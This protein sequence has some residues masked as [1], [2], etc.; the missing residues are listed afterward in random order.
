MK[1]VLT[2]GAGFLGFHLSRG[3]AEHDR[4]LLDL[5]TVAGDELA[6]AAAIRGDVRDRELLRRAFD[7]ADAVVHAAAALPLWKPAEIRSVNTDG[8]RAVLDAA[9]ELGV[10]RLLHVSSTAVYGI[11]DHHPLDE[12]D[13]MHGVGPYGE[14]KVAAERLVE[15]ARQR[16]QAVA[17]VR[18]KTFLGPER[19]GV[20]Q[21]LFEW[22]RQGRRIPVIGGGRNRYQLLDVEDLVAAVRL[23]LELPAGQANA[24]FNVGAGDFGS[25]EEDLGAL[26]EHAGSGSRLLRTPAWL[27]KGSLSALEALR[28]SPL[29]KWVYGTADQDSWVETGRL[30]ALGWEPRWSNAGTLIRT[31][32]WYL[33]NRAGLSQAGVGHRT[34]WREGALA[35]LRRFL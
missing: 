15:E 27:A 14:S 35:I 32:D 16:G 3:L 10:P 22:V 11:P 19:L 29:Y 33:A 25:V 8:T 17:V 26:F 7:G 2:G 5:E 20:F 1:V 13:A 24:T 12:D 4:L 23:L 9:Q 31:Y 34:P 18:P 30:R 28:L 21:I 6:G